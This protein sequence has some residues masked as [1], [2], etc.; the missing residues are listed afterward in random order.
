MYP[1]LRSCSASS[2]SYSN[3][4]DGI[5]DILAGSAIDV[6]HALE[7]ARRGLMP[8]ILAERTTAHDEPRRAEDLPHP[9]EHS[10]AIL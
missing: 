5:R 7:C 1:K 2:G 8:L 9:R 6:G 10:F 4:L 3:S